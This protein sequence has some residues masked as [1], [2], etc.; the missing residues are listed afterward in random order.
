VDIDALID[1]IC[2][3]VLERL[4]ALEAQQNASRCDTCSNESCKEYTISKH[5][6]TEKNV[7]DAHAERAQKIV[8]DSKAILTDLAKEYAHKRNIAIER[9][10]IS[11]SARGNRI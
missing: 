10:D 2:K 5:V 9:R 4:Q 8:V 11:S 6:I 3:K 1:E 7:I